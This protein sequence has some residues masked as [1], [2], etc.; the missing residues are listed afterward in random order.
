MSLSWVDLFFHVIDF[1]FDRCKL[2][3]IESE[4]LLE[5]KFLGRLEKRLAGRK[6]V[7]DS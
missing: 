7:V 1:S 4:S 3:M 2:F 6:I 5:P